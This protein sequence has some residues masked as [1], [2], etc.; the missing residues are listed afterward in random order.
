MESLTRSE[1]VL[2]NRSCRFVVDSFSRRK[3]FNSGMW[4]LTALLPL[5]GIMDVIPSGAAQWVQASFTV[6]Y[7]FVYS[8][9]IGAM[10]FVL[11][12]EVSSMALRA[13]TT[14]LATAT[15]SL[16]GVIINIAIPYMVNPDEADL[17]GKVGFVFGGLAIIGAVGAW[18]YVPELKGRTTSEI[19]IMFTRR[20]PSRKMGAYEIDGEVCL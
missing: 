5:I 10:A 4:C 2:T 16:L 18:I 19:D 7:A 11:L 8:M 13:H 14:A 3:V 6:I 9:T 20:V 15:Q 12:G 1:S 17:K